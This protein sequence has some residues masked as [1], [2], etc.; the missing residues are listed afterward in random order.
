MVMV[1]PSTIG[2]EDKGAFEM[3]KNK[4]VGVLLIVSGSLAI[5]AF[6]S[7]AISGS[8]SYDPSSESDDEDSSEDYYYNDDDDIESDFSFDS[9]EES[10]SSFSLFGSFCL[11]SSAGYLA[12]G[13]IGIIGGVKALKGT[14]KGFVY[15]AAIFNMVVGLIPYVVFGAPGLIALILWSQYWKEENDKWTHNTQMQQLQAQQRTLLNMQAAAATAP[16]IIPRRQDDYRTPPAS[17]PPVSRPDIRPAPPSARGSIGP[18]IRNIKVKVASPSKV[19]SPSIADTIPGY[20]ITHKL[21]SG[22]FAKVYKAR[23]DGGREVAIKMPKFIDQTL[24]SSIYE[25]FES[26]ANMWNKLDHMNIVDFYE[27]NLDPIPCLVME[28]AEGGSLKELLDHRRLSTQEAMSIFIQLVDAIS[29]AHRMASVHRDIKPENV[30]FTRDGIPKLT[31]WG[32]GKMMAAESATKTVGAK[33]TLA[34]SAPE[35]I[36]KKK[37]GQVDWSTD[38]FQIG[39]VGYEMLTDFNP[40]LDDDP[41]GIMG[42]IINEEVPPPSEYNS[43]VPARVDTVILRAL[44][45]RKEDRWRSADV[46][47]DRLKQAVSSY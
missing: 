39:I 19:V 36:S 45:K 20:T 22:G 16:P 46:M 43:D 10:S 24:D 28:L 13:I 1:N 4:A 14:S 41:V 21:G 27:Y 23:D 2:K 34:Y 38:I 33:G 15:F 18:M 7:I 25:K 31:D 32:I 35:Q 40:F 5:L 29:Y 3:G 44:E 30:L 26:E 12:A 6:I 42:K 11:M 37:Y 8:L 47:Y 17:P 9:R